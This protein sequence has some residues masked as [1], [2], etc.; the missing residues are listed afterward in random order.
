MVLLGDRDSHR[1]FY[2]D[3]YYDVTPVRD[4]DKIFKLNHIYIL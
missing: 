2:Y 4:D 3:I 1:I